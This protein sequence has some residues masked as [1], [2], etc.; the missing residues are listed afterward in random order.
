MYSAYVWFT[1]LNPFQTQMQHFKVRG[2]TITEPEFLLILEE[3]YKKEEGYPTQITRILRM[4][5]ACLNVLGCKCLRHLLSGFNGTL[6]FSEILGF[7]TP[8][9]KA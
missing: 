6:K 8:W 7:A 9:G 5:P 1:S 4:S 2:K 3:F